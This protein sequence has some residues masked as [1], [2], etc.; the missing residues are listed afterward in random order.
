MAWVAGLRLC[1]DRSGPARTGR[2]A[3]YAA[4]ANSVLAFVLFPCL[5]RLRGSRLATRP[6]LPP[7]RNQSPPLVPYIIARRVGEVKHRW[8]KGRVRGSLYETNPRNGPERPVMGGFLG[9]PREP[10]RIVPNLGTIEVGI[11]AKMG[12]ER[13][14]RRSFCGFLHT[15]NG[16][17]R[18]QY[19]YDRT[20]YGYDRTQYGYGE[21]RERGRRNGGRLR[22]AAGVGWGLVCRAG[23]A[24]LPA[25][26]EGGG[27][28][29]AD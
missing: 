24:G 23:M 26:R 19:G 6:F 20:Q 10:E 3:D 14:L 13:G 15:Q 4:R 18:T 17:D 22:R 7:R 27:S 28:L 9:F 11:Y 21:R 16:Y 29:G 1:L 5:T 8:G 12:A 25:P 2:Q